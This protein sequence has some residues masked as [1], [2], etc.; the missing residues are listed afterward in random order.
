MKAWPLALLVASCGAPPPP[1]PAPPPVATSLSREEIVR[2]LESLE[3]T[4]YVHWGAVEKTGEF[5]KLG[6]AP[7]PLLREIA[8]AN[9]EQALMACRVLGRLAPRE[10]FSDPAKA[11]LYVTAFEREANFARWGTLSKRGLLPGVYGAELLALGEASVPHLQK[12]LSDR[13]RARIRSGDEEEAA[14]RA[15]GDRVCDYAWVM[16]ATILRRPFDYVA[17]PDRRDFEIREFDL[18]L[19]RRGTFKR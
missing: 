16:L 18:W 15:Q 2:L 9:G 17:E 3:R 19:G 10:R 4:F 5:A 13:R 8:D 6:A 11:I 7:V 14:N 1:A 12:S